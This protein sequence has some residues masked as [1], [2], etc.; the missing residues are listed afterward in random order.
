MGKNNTNSKGV[1]V[2][3]FPD[4]IPLTIMREIW[5]DTDN[6]YTDAQ[7]IKMREW[8][9]LL[10]EVIFDI[11]ARKKASKIININQISNEAAESNIIHQGQH[12]RAS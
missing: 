8:V 2:E 7:L 5:N 10:A 4:K 9:Y 12:R 6:I 3:L 1:I 11:A